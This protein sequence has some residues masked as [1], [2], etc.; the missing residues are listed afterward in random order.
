[1]GRGTDKPFQ[2]F[3]HPNLCIGD[4]YFTPQTIAGVSENPPQKGKKCR[5]IDLTEVAIEH[6]Q[7]HTGSCNLEYLLTAYKNFPKEMTFFTNPD[8]FDKLAGSSTLRWQIINGKT[9]QEIHDSWVPALEKFKETRSKY[10][11]YPE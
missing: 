11:I 4:F 1:V 6:L 3:G 8:F 9:Q 10:L 7:L 5:C 2:V